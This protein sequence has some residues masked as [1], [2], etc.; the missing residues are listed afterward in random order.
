MKIEFDSTTLSDMD[1]LKLCMALSM[2]ATNA[3]GLTKEFIDQLKIAQVD[4]C[5][6]LETRG[7]SEMVNIMFRAIEQMGTVS[8]LIDEFKHSI[9]SK[10]RER[11]EGI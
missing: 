2:T 6:E 8:H 1:L 9:I 3:D 5:C 10:L 7:K 11:G 4:I